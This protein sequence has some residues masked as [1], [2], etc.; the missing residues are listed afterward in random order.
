MASATTSTNPFTSSGITTP[1]LQLQYK[2]ATLTAVPAAVVIQSKTGSVKKAA[3]VASG[4]TGSGL[5]FQQFLVFME[6]LS[7]TIYAY[8]QQHVHKTV[9]A[10]APAKVAAKTTHE[11]ELVFAGSEPAAVAASD[12]P[13]AAD[14]GVSIE[15][16]AYSLLQSVLHKLCLRQ[17][18]LQGLDALLENT[19]LCRSGMTRAAKT[20]FASS[21]STLLLDPSYPSTY[22][23]ETVNTRML[24][25][26]TIN[27]EQVCDI[28]CC[29]CNIKLLMFSMFV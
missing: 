25:L 28:G 20:A 8:Y 9:A 7:T 11:D 15:M 10:T 12:A 16:S 23:A 2:K 14:T 22:S 1:F 29:V 5:T 27:T 21:G 19:R 4:D 24:Q 18:K 17:S 6:T 13:A 3:K 26:W